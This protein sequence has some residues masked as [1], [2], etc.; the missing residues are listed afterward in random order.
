[1][2]VLNINLK[3][4]CQMDCARQGRSA[5]ECNVICGEVGLATDGPDVDFSING[6]NHDS[7][8]FVECGQKGFGARDCMLQCNDTTTT[9]E[10]TQNL[11]IRKCLLIEFINRKPNY[12]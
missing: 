10:R 4:E 9:E 12:T 2:I 3:P 5:R 8:C 1:M 6:G 11:M 7:G